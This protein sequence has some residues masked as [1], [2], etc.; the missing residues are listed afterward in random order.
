[1][2]LLSDGTGE[3]ALWVGVKSIGRGGGVGGM[4][5]LQ[6]ERGGVMEVGSIVRESH[7][8]VTASRSGLRNRGWGGVEGGGGV[9]NV[10]MEV[11]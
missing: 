4:G 1:M 8:L 2:K 7:S 10:S 3:S 5:V 9:Q 11:K 6:R